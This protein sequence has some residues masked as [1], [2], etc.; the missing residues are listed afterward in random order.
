M[1]LNEVRQ[2]NSSICT[3]RQCGW[4]DAVA[5]P[6]Y[7]NTGYVAGVPRLGIPSLRETDASLGVTNPLGICPADLAT[8]LP[9]S[10]ALAASFVRRLR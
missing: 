7:E 1:W 4:D 10:L 6:G 9:S 3:G 2:E 8:A 5:L